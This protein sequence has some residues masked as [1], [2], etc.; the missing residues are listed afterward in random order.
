MAIKKMKIQH[1]SIIILVSLFFINCSKE[2]SK[3][4]AVI[5]SISSNQTFIGDTLTLMGQNL[6]EVG[7]LYLIT[8]S[9]DIPNDQPTIISRDNTEIQFVIPELY[10]EE[11][12][13]Y[14]SGYDSP[15]DLELKGFIPFSRRF[16]IEGPYR[17]GTGLMK[18]GQIVNDDLS[19]F[20]PED[21]G[22]LKATNRLDDQQMISIFDDKKVVDC[23]FFNEERGWV[24][25]VTGSWFY[26]YNF[27][28]TEDGGD[29]ISLEYSIN[30]A[31]VE[32][33]NNNSSIRSVHFIN[34]NLGYVYTNHGQ[35]IRFNNGVFE[36]MANIYSEVEYTN[37][38]AY[39]EPEITDNGIVYLH[40][41]G[42]MTLTRIEN[43]SVSVYQ[44][45]S[46]GILREMKFFD[47]NLGFYHTYD[48]KVF[49]TIDGGV[50]WNELDINNTFTDDNRVYQSYRYSFIEEN[51]II[52]NREYNYSNA[53]TFRYEYHISYDQGLTWNICLAPY[54][55]ENINITNL[56]DSFGL[57][58][59]NGNSRYFKF[60]KFPNLD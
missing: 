53:V 14:I 3:P 51:Q 55:F 13:L 45:P 22:L 31:D 16:S 8:P 44:I 54:E 43:N 50:T 34:E 60:I 41:S 24:V 46:E 32:I 10:H 17:E 36:N 19:F 9:V 1:I 23:H 7:N 42:N 27:Y 20:I 38:F 5:D 28:F 6:D 37:D 35:I 57:A 40:K 39:G 56:N 47:N 59:S 15:I 58:V 25:T 29:S 26:T 52:R 2:D 4:K 33:N 12:T 21:S 49:K 30:E 11:V 18:L 48:N